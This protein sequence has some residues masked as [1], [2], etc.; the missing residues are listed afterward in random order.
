VGFLIRWATWPARALIYGV[1]R[2]VVRILG[3]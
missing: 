1:A 3:I 2:S